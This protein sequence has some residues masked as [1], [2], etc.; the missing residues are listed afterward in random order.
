MPGLTKR[1]ILITSRQAEEEAAGG[2]PTLSVT[3]GLIGRWRANAGVTLSGSDVTAVADQSGSGNN[4][5]NDGTVPYNATGFNGKPSFDFAVGNDAALFC[6][7][8]PFGAIDDLTVVAIAQMDSATAGFGGLVVYGDGAGNDYN[9]SGYG[10]WLGR[11]DT[12][13]AVNTTSFDALPTITS[14]TA[15]APHVI[16]F[17]KEGGVDRSHWIDGV[18]GTP[19]APGANTLITNGVL[20]IGNRYLSGAVGG[21]AWDGQ[22]GE[23]LVYN[24]DLSDVEIGTIQ[25]YAEHVDGWAL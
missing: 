16:V 2:W 25:T 22:V 13:N 20:A 12:N 18:E 5:V 7:P 9:T 17:R 11:D 1:R 21:A 4:L 19:V 15:N 14:M 8:F 3:S 10:A 23:V 24:R 6:D